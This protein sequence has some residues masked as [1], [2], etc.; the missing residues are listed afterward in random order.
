MPSRGNIA[1]TRAKDYTAH[2][3]QKKSLTREKKLE[4]ECMQRT[5]DDRRW[6]MEG[7]FS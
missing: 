3:G 4:A 1:L 5:A 6:A 7:G 2:A